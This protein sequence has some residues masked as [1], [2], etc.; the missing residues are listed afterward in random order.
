MY[1]N[2]VRIKQER[3]LTEQEREE[4]FR[5]TEEQKRLSDLLDSSLR[6]DPVLVLKNN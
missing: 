5:L 1:K 2:V 4:V 3:A 6:L